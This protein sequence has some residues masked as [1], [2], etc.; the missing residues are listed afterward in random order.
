MYLLNWWSMV[1]PIPI[2]IAINLEEKVLTE[3]WFKYYTR[4]LRE[5]STNTYHIENVNDVD[6]ENNQQM[7]CLFVYEHSAMGENYV[8]IY[9]R[10]HVTD[11]LENK[12]WIYSQIK[13]VKI[14]G[15]WSRIYLLGKI[16][17]GKGLST[18][19]HLLVTTYCLYCLN[20]WNNISIVTPLFLRQNDFENNKEILLVILNERKECK[21]RSQVIG[22]GIYT[23]FFMLLDTRPKLTAMS[24]WC[25]HDWKC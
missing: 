4:C 2:I 23:N 20:Y 15:L 10:N 3:K 7:S 6:E 16:M 25:V 19:K 24:T 9:H 14:F 12:F 1:S 17:L 22:K 18:P 11:H 21:G 8:A 5:P 13:Q